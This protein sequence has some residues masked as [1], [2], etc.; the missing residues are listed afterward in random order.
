MANSL[1]EPL[2]GSS[3]PQLFRPRRSSSPSR[4]PIITCRVLTNSRDVLAT[5]PRRLKSES[6]EVP[7]LIL[8]PS[9]ENADLDSAKESS[10]AA[11]EMSSCETIFNL[12]STMV[13]SGVLAVPYAF[14]LTSY[15]AVALLLL[16]VAFT[17]FTACLIGESLQLLWSFGLPL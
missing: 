1:E 17:A 8:A 12:A 4:Q 2:Q 7:D 3:T 11:E 6:L 14:R 5:P 10:E 9:Q 15:W 13:G 16:V